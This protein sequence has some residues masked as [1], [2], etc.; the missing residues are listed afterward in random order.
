MWWRTPI[1]TRGLDLWRRRPREKPTLQTSLPR[2]SQAMSIVATSTSQEHLHDI[3]RRYYREF[4]TLTQAR[5]RPRVQLRLTGYPAFAHMPSTSRRDQ[6]LASVFARDQ[7]RWLP[8][9]SR[10]DTHTWTTR[11]T[12]IPRTHANLARRVC[13]RHHQL[14]I[15]AQTIQSVDGQPHAPRAHQSKACVG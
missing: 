9:S 4:R 11:L 15:R 7:N 8:T 13:T 12:R 6:T 14:Q 5:T 3:A 2:G 1:A 10:Q